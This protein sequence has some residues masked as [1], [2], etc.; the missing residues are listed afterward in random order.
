MAT[1]IF[2][3]IEILRLNPAGAWEH[4]GEYVG[5]PQ[6]ISPFGDWTMPYRKYVNYS[7]RVIG[8][9][10]GPSEATIRDTKLTWN[11]IA[12]LKATH[13]ELLALKEATTEENNFWER[14]INTY[15]DMNLIEFLSSLSSNPA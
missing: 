9:T 1:S 14:L 4:K 12:L 3:I 13:K 6:W 7:S 15:K 8:T 5:N 11:K 10:G 2:G